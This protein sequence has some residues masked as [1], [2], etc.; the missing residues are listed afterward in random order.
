[1][2]GAIPTPL[3][4][5]ERLLIVWPQVSGLLATT[6]VCFALAYPSFMRR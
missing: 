5:R 3:P 2:A 4:F 6:V 1:M